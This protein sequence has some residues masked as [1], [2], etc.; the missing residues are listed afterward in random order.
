[1]LLR[2]PCSLSFLVISLEQTSKWRGDY[3]ID[4]GCPLHHSFVIRALDSWWSVV[5]TSN[6]RNMIQSVFINPSFN[7]KR[8]PKQRSDISHCPPFWRNPTSTSPAYHKPRPLSL[9]WNLKRRRSHFVTTPTISSIPNL[10]NNNAR[11]IKQNPRTQTC[12]RNHSPLSHPSIHH[13]K[14]TSHAL[15]PHLSSLN[16][17]GHFPNMNSPYSAPLTQNETNIWDG[18]DL[19]PDASPLLSQAIDSA[20]QQVLH[21]GNVTLSFTRSHHFKFKRRA[22]EESFRVTT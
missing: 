18:F 1:M 19:S 12:K 20:L 17:R 14:Y 4:S 6:R 3:A 21:A 2:I 16:E 7:T 22:G 8:L 10:N 13:S 15:K 11:E 9:K 5:P